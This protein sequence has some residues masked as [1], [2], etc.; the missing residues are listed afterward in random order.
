MSE[1]QLYSD[2]IG[3][4]PK[5][6]AEGSIYVNATTKEKYRLINDSWVL[7]EDTKNG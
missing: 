3:V 6:A 2:S 4:F 7:I 1:P 5:D